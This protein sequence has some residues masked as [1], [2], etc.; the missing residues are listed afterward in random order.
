VGIWKEHYRSLCEY[1][2]HRLSPAETKGNQ[3][4]SDRTAGS[5]VETRTGYVNTASLERYI[6]LLDGNYLHWCLWTTNSCGQKQLPNL[7]P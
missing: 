2:I 1:T 7:R 6:N 3:E 5:P 4:R